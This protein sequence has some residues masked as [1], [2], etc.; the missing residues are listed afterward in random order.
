MQGRVIVKTIKSSRDCDWCIAGKCF[1]LNSETNGDQLNQCEESATRF[2]DHCPL[3][4][5]FDNTLRV[6]VNYELRNWKCS[7]AKTNE[8]R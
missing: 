3:P 4:L 7:K 1:N 6:G 2:P 5:I 8:T